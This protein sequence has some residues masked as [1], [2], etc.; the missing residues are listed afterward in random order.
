VQFAA[1]VQVA[2]AEA[3]LPSTKALA[4]T[5]TPPPPMPPPPEPCAYA[6]A[7]DFFLLGSPANAERVAE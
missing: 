6:D 3:W 5:E 1:P 4:D 2:D 7:H